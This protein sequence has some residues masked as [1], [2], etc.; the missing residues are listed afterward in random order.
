MSRTLSASKRFALSAS[1]IR[2]TSSPRDRACARPSRARPVSPPA[3]PLHALAVRLEV[4]GV[5]D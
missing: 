3:P 4:H 5:S 2:P 1:C